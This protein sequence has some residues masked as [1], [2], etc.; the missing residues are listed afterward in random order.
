M[1]TRNPIEMPVRAR[2]RACVQVDMV[3][4]FPLVPVLVRLDDFDGDI[5][6]DYWHDVSVS[7]SAR[8]HSI[9]I[10]IECAQDSY[11]LLRCN[12]CC[13]LSSPSF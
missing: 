8:P 7:N 2:A 13:R 1:A 11:P 10:D 3:T 5:W 4:R 12:T 9:F 6:I